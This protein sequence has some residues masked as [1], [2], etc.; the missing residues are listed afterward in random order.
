MSMDQGMSE[1]VI[2]FRYFIVN[3]FDKL[4]MTCLFCRIA[5]RV[6]QPE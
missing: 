6:H 3:D 5:F 4:S 1:I 2:Q